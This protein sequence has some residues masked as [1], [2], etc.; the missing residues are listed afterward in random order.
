MNHGLLRPAC[1]KVD[2][3]IEHFHILMAACGIGGRVED[4]FEGVCETRV[5]L[6]EDRYREVTSRLL[7]PAR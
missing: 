5:V 1:K 6:I 2:R 3:I 7:C 4:P